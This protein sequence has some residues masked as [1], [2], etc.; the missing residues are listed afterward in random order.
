V[1]AG[2][3]ART[4]SPRNVRK[5]ER[6]HVGDEQDP[7]PITTTARSGGQRLDKWLWFARFAKTRTLASRMVESGRVRVNRERVSKSAHLVRQDD[8]VAVALGGSIRIARV[9]HLGERRGP[10]DEARALY[11]DLTP[12]AVKPDAEIEPATEAERERGAGRPTK[13]DRRKID[14]WRGGNDDPALT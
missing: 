7:P 10:A 8:V 9:I 4:G 5:S 11:D 13:R 2:R 3:S 14:A 1:S 12:P 6:H